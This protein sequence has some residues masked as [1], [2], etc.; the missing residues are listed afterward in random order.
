MR[1][2]L[3]TLILMAIAAGFGYSA[4]LKAKEGEYLGLK[5]K[6]TAVE[7]TADS[8]KSTAE[9]L[10]SE[11]KILTDENETLR[12]TAINAIAALQNSVLS[13][14]G[15]VADTTTKALSREEL[16]NRLIELGKK[17]KGQ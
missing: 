15:Q 8:A 7:K 9:A 3:I 6:M 16:A 10:K 12:K 11:K 4:G 5:E 13:T 14:S 2:L 17:L 1:R